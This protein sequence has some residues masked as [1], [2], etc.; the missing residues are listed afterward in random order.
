MTVGDRLSP[1]LPD[2]P[3]ALNHHRHGEEGRSFAQANVADV[4]SIPA[5]SP[6]V[7]KGPAQRSLFCPRHPLQP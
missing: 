1:E 2:R 7:G 4:M 5:E 3:H 6:S